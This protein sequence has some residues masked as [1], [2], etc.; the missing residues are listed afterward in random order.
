M[1]GEDLQSPAPQPNADDD[2]DD[3]DDNANIRVLLQLQ[4]T[5]I[6]LNDV[7]NYL[8]DTR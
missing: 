8:V 1:D 7:K 2:D 5:H 3:D 4:T 6:F